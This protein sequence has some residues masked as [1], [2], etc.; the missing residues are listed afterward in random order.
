MKKTLVTIIMCVISSF[1]FS[2]NSVNF[3]INVEGTFHV[4]DS[5]KDYYVFSFPGKSASKL[6]NLALKAATK[7]YT[8]TDDNIKKV[9]NQ[10]ITIT[11]SCQHQEEMLFGKISYRKVFYAY[12][13]EFKTGKI[14]IN[15]PRTIKVILHH[16]DEEAEEHPF[17]YIQNRNTAKMNRWFLK[18]N[19]SIN[20]LLS[21]MTDKNDENW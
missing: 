3:T 4:P 7:I 13:I 5:E 17:D 6:Y 20:K 16:D 21:S 12:D 8:S 9:Q 1:A 11:S 10:M 15:A 14:R 19:A 2:Q 18:M